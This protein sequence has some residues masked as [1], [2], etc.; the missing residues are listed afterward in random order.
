M[1]SQLVFGWDRLE[2]FLITCDRP[3]GNV[4]TNAKCQS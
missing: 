1:G 3:V 4:V 2:I